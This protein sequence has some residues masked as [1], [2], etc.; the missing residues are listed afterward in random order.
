M[1]NSLANLNENV[2]ALM[3]FKKMEF[4]LSQAS[5]LFACQLYVSF[6]NSLFL[7]VYD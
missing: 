7:N 3:L 5:E 1:L 2:E 6:P 4:N